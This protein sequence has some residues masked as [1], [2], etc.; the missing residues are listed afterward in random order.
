LCTGTR[1]RC[2]GG[3]QASAIGCQDR[4][5]L[6]ARGR[7]RERCALGRLQ[8]PGHFLAPAALKD[9]SLP[10]LQ[11]L[12]QVGKAVQLS[13]SLTACV[14]SRYAMGVDGVHAPHTGACGSRVTALRQA[15]G[16]EGMGTTCPSTDD[17]VRCVL[18]EFSGGRDLSF[19]KKRR[20]GDT[21]R[22]PQCDLCHTPAEHYGSWHEVGASSIAAS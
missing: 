11:E 18:L 10:V 16:A 2:R 20:R 6:R 1:G 15:L 14:V 21:L 9:K 19:C 4:L 22:G 13:R 12:L 8:Q 17:V 7:C 5:V 3:H